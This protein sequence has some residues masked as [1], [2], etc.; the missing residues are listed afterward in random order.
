MNNHAT[1]EQRYAERG[2]LYSALNRIGISDGVYRVELFDVEI[3]RHDDG[4]KYCV[5]RYELEEDYIF[6]GDS[7][8]RATFFGVFSLDDEKLARSKID[9]LFDVFGWPVP[10]RNDVDDLIYYAKIKPDKVM[11]ANVTK[12]KV[13]FSAHDGYNDGYL[14]YDVDP[15][16]KVKIGDTAKLL[17]D[18]ERYLYQVAGLAWKKVVIGVNQ[19]GQPITRQD[20]IEE[21]LSK[22][23]RGKTVGDVIEHKGGKYKIVEIQRGK[24]Q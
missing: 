1:P 3:R 13:F 10:K 18:G 12:T 22:A 23:L 24:R 21:P 20:K 5:S 2:T 14:L 6:R 17:R 7:L 4:R 8:P 9:K 16:I 19:D 15:I 11:T